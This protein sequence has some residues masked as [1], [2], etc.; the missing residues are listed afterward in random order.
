[1]NLIDFPELHR[2]FP[3]ADLVDMVDIDSGDSILKIVPA[4]ELMEWVIKVFI[5]P[6]SPIYNPDHEH[7]KEMLESD[8]EFLTFAW[9]SAPFKSKQAVV[10][11]QCEKVMFNVGGWRKAR[12]EQQMIDWFGFVPKYLITVA[13][14]FCER[15]NNRDFCALIDHE[16]YHIGVERDEEGDIVYSR[17][18]GLPKHHLAAHDVEEFIGVVKRWGMNESVK[19]LVQV[20]QN[21]PFVP[22]VDISKC[23]G[24][25]VIN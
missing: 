2:P 13:A 19:R 22:D 24:T 11:G 1:M 5:T 10:L 4:P 23:C 17:F 16:L 8:N 3:P 9:A 18:T 25:C 7:I 20:A 12:Q 14:N 15:S 6:G 21:P